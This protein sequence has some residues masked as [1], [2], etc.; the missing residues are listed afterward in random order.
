MADPFISPESEGAF[1]ALDALEQEHSHVLLFDRATERWREAKALD[2][3]LLS[4]VADVT[5]PGRPQ[6]I[7]NG[8]PNDFV[9]VKHDK[10]LLLPLTPSVQE[11][12]VTSARLYLPTV[13]ASKGTAGDQDAG[14]RTVIGLDIYASVRN[15]D[16]ETKRYYVNA[17]GDVQEFL[18]DVHVAAGEGVSQL[19]RTIDDEDDG[20]Q[21]R[22]IKRI[23]WNVAQSY[24]VVEQTQK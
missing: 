1:D 14:A 21:A 4:F 15:S 12:D 24:S 6:R 7:V 11:G 20:T 8:Q 16:G 17:S 22:D 19:W 13:S 2:F 5:A 9:Q 10:L 18:G 23:L 3:H